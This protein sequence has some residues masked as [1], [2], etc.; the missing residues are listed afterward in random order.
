MSEAKK[1]VLA[2]IKKKQKRIIEHKKRKFRGPYSIVHEFINAMD[3]ILEQSKTQE[4]FSMN[5]QSAVNT[6]NNRMKL[7]DPEVDLRIVWNKSDDD[8][9]K[10]LRVD[11]IE[12]TWSRFHLSKNNLKEPTKY[13]DVGMLFMEGY[14]TE[15]EP[16]DE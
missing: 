9:W 8:D 2:L 10:S 7:L 4:V 6:F 11:G 3:D 5:M 16:G 14:F 13:I 12:I 15:Q 1:R